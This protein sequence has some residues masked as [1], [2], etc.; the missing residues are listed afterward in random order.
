M[1]ETGF[2]VLRHWMK[3]YSDWAIQEN[4]QKNSKNGP[5]WTLFDWLMAVA[6]VALFS[7]VAFMMLSSPGWWGW[8][9]DVLDARYWGHWTWTGVVV[10][11]LVVLAAIRYWPEKQPW[12][13]RQPQTKVLEGTADGRR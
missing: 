5:G 4:M 10:S 8:C 1:N 7:G 2:P 13:E 11:L 3:S 12:P 9:L 6:I